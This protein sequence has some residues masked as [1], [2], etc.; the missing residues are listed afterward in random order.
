MAGPRERR[1]TEAKHAR[2]GGPTARPFCKSFLLERI[3]LQMGLA[4]RRLAADCFW[5]SRP[6]FPPPSPQTR[7]GKGLRLSSG[8][9]LPEG[10][11]F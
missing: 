8:T 4:G 11:D 9:G 5:L 7:D 1:P 6:T 2:R 10:N 3:L